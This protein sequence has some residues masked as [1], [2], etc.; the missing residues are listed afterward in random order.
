[1]SL[2]TLEVQ[3]DRGRVTPKEPDLLPEAGTGLL[4]ILRSE[5]ATSPPRERVSLPLIR[6]VPGTIV[7]PTAEEL[8]ASF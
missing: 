8:D 1:M 7:N 6:C 5:R 2:I 3:I 4:T